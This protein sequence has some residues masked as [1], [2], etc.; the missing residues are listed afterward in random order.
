M[1]DDNYDFANDVL[2]LHDVLDDNGQVWDD[3]PVIDDQDPEPV[4]PDDSLPLDIQDNP[5]DDPADPFHD[6][7]L[8]P[9]EDDDVPLG[10][11]MHNSLWNEEVPGLLPNAEER[12]IVNNHAQNSNKPDDPS[13][14][15]NISFLGESSSCSDCTGSCWLTCSGSCTS[16]NSSI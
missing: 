8:T 3:N 11:A 2:D 7:N 16:S 9:I 1:F 5:I 4:F 14:E 15:Q 10:E 6:D 13:D 12:T